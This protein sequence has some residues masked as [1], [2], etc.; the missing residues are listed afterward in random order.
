MAWWPD[1]NYTAKF[2]TS[3]IT[4][5]YITNDDQALEKATSAGPFADYTGAT[6]TCLTTSAAVSCSLSTRR[7]CGAF[8]S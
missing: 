8:G 6:R 4:Y 1:T 2:G 3:G 7:C 5:T